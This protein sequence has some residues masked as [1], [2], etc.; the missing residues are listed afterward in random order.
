M[1][2][3]EVYAAAGNKVI[4]YIRG[5]QAGSLGASAEVGKM[6]LFGD[7]IIALSTD[8][9]KLFVWSLK[10]MSAYLNPCLHRSSTAN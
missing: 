9:T 4:K 2:G 3:K 5:K 6:L 10:S 1:T 8:G 7:Q